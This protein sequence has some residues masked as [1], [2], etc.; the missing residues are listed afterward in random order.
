MHRAETN[1]GWLEKL[2]D[3]AVE[4]LPTT[5]RV[6]LFNTKKH[7]AAALEVGNKVF[8]VY[9]TF[10]LKAMNIYSTRQANIGLLNVEEFT[11]LAELLWLHQR[12]FF[13]LYGKTI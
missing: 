6:K 2:V 3:L 10:I 7:V 5:K 9:V 11:I 4:A 8:V 1:D 13:R 12:L